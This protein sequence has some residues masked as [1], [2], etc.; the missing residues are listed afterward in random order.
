MNEVNIIRE[1]LDELAIEQHT[2]PGYGIQNQA[3][4]ESTHLALHLILLNLESSGQI[5]P[6]V[7]KTADWLTLK[8]SNVFKVMQHYFYILRK[9]CNK[10][11]PFE[12]EMD[13]AQCEKAFKHADEVLEL[14]E[15]H[16]STLISP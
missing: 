6:G 3:L 7:K 16:K 10:D 2:V 13:M 5:Y 1:Q 8:F 11:M 12:I 4:F 15:T 14:Y 9:H